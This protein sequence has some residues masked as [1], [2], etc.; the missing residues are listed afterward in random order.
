MSATIYDIKKTGIVFLFNHYISMMLENSEYINSQQRATTT[1]DMIKLCEEAIEK[2]DEFHELDHDN[3]KVNRWL[4][5]IQG[6][7]ISVGLVTI[8]DQRNFTRPYLTEHRNKETVM[9]NNT[10]YE[11]VD[12]KHDDL[13]D[14]IKEIFDEDDRCGCGHDWSSEVMSTPISESEVPEYLKQLHTWDTNKVTDVSNIGSNDKPIVQFF[15]K[16]NQIIAD[17]EEELGDAVDCLDGMS[18]LQSDNIP[19]TCSLVLVKSGD[20]FLGVSRKHDHNDIGLPGGK[21]EMNETYEDCAIRE[22][23][24]ETGYVIKLLEAVPFEGIDLGLFCKTYL[25]EIVD[26]I[27]GDKD[28]SETGVV[29]LFDKQAFLDG[30]F[31]K[32]NELMFKHFGM[33]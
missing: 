27:S 21:R 16:W 14:V 29:G 1:T 24:E 33:E 4:G 20:K 2:Y 12:I 15:G 18:Q 31:S 30:S 8:E 19:V 28:S 3:S 11:I 5:Y 26:T 23:M 9:S 13:P 6:I 17:K 32:Y 7:L 25:A 22:T 10:N